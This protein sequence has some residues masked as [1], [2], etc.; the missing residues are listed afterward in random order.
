MTWNPK[1]LLLTGSYGNGHLKVTKTLKDMFLKLGVDQDNIVESDLYLASHPILTKASKYLYIKSFTYG[2]K[3]Y[4]FLYYGGSK[5][6]RIVSYDFLNKYGMSTM[7]QLVDEVKPD[8]IVNTFP[9]LV[10]PEFR[11]R[12]GAQIPIVHVVTDYYAHKN[13]I[14]EEVDRYYVATEQLK[15]DLMN[16]GF[17]CEQIKVSGIP[18]DS[19]FEEEYDKQALFDAYQLDSSRPVVLIAAGAY[20]V[21]KDFDETMNKLL[22]GNR[23]QIMV[24]CGKNEE[25]KNTLETRFAGNKNVVIFGYTNKM[26]ELMKM[27][28]VMV[29]KPGGIT[30]SEA[31][32][33]Q[34]P[35]ILYRPVPGQEKENALFFESKGAA[36]QVERPSL[37]LGSI[38]N[39]LEDEKLRLS[40][41]KSMKALY[42][43][44]SSEVI[45]QDVLDIALYSDKE[46]MNRIIV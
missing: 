33:V 16:Q 29:T 30:L 45:C 17:S 22:D 42:N 4:G 44:N 40:M 24:V 39:L 18:I 38:L 19:I 14:H 21:L 43:E 20:G 26:D 15:C 25:L 3:I 35:L 36:I 8:I 28:T 46:K 9:M 32:A 23:N 1:I 11:K 7:K 13:W 12:T 34:V 41:K 6:K 37:L 10:V 2:K 5:N 27:A 31:L